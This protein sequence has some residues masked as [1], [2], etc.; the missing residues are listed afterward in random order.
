MSG[1]LYYSRYGVE[2]WH[3]DCV[4]LSRVWTGADVLLTDPPYGVQ[5]RSLHKAQRRVNG[6]VHI[7]GDDSTVLRDRA[8]E[9]WREVDPEGV[10][11]V[12]VFGSWK[13]P[14][15]VWTRQRLIW[16]K[17]PSDLANLKQVF[18][19]RDE[20]IYI[21]GEGWVRSTAAPSS[22]LS[23]HS[24]QAAM[25][26]R[27]GHAMAKPVEVLQRLLG[28][29]VIPE[30]GVIADPFAG[31]GSTLVAAG[32]LGLGAVGVELEERF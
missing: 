13:Q 10:K 17:R 31:V 12:A 23:V 5:V 15:P 1:S 6:G 20:E 8:L 22:T 7:S 14:R 29:M 4:E 9:L 32:L 25:S 28:R 27:L 26:A 11:P 30:G 3:G 21:W 24:P 16:D 18:N 2:L 19:Q